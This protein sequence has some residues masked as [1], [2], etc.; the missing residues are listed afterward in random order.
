MSDLVHF[1]QLF[2]KSPSMF[3]GWQKRFFFLK[4]RELKWFKEKFSD[5]Q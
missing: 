3:K 5:S 1:G 2:K 4:N